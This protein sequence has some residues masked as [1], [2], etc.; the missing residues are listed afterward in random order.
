MLLVVGTL[1]KIKYVAF[2]GYPILV[3]VWIEMRSMYV[4][5]RLSVFSIVATEIVKRIHRIL[6][7]L[8]IHRCIGF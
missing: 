6:V 5:Q 3:R 8:L 2:Y 1:V 4:R 7:K